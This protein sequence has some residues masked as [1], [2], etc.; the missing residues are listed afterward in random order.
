MQSNNHS[1]SVNDYYAKKVLMIVMLNNEF[2]MQICISYTLYVDGGGRWR[3]GE[4]RE[5]WNDG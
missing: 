5:R 4:A 1:Y 3:E 2:N